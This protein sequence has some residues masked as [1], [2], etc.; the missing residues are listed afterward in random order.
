MGLRDL[1]QHLLQ[2][3]EDILHK[4]QQDLDGIAKEVISRTQE[5]ENAYKEQAS[6]EFLQKR[7][8]EAAEKQNSSFF[9]D[10][11]EWAEE[12]TTGVNER[13]VRFTTSANNGR[14]GRQYASVEAISVAYKAC[15]GSETDVARLLAERGDLTV[16]DA[17][18]RNRAAIIR[19]FSDNEDIDRYD[20]GDSKS[21]KRNIRWCLAHQDMSPA[22]RRRTRALANGKQRN[23]RHRRRNNN[24]RSKS[25]KTSKYQ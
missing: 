20:Y 1:P 2:K 18:A 9:V 3:F 19:S 11:D 7:A 4:H 22:E 17:S 15:R 21:R 8:S 5:L 13:L 14:I 24:R 23:R 10:S 16:P 6:I 25:T 12:H